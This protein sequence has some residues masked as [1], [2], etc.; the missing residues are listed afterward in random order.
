MQK[1]RL[2]FCTG[3]FCLSEKEVRAVSQLEAECEW[4]TTDGNQPEI[5]AKE[6][7]YEA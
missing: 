2:C 3:A 6:A 4:E 1:E 7:Q 5:G